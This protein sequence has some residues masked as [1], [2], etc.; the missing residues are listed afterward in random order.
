MD[1]IA[2]WALEPMSVSRAIR[3][4]QQRGL[5]VRRVGSSDRRS[6]ELS[7]TRKGRRVYDTVVPEANAR[8]H[9]IVDCLPPAERARLARALGHADR[10]HQA[11]GV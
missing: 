11:V 8:Y 6:Q 7:L 5:I 3:E 2:H 4:L 9:E 10:E 1:I